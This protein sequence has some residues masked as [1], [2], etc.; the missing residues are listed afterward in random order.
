MDKS[1]TN[2]TEEHLNDVSSV[3][4]EKS[5]DLPTDEG[6][7][8]TPINNIEVYKATLTAIDEIDQ[9]YSSKNAELLEVINQRNALLDEIKALYK[10]LADIREDVLKSNELYE[11]FKRD[12]AQSVAE[13][14]WGEKIFYALPIYDEYDASDPWVVQ[15][16]DV[17]RN[18]INEENRENIRNFIN[19]NFYNS[20]FSLPKDIYYYKINPKELKDVNPDVSKLAYIFST[21]TWIFFKFIKDFSDNLR[22]TLLK[23]QLFA[24][25]TEDDFEK[26]EIPSQEEI[27]EDKNMVLTNGDSEMRMYEKYRNKGKLTEIIKN[28]SDYI[29][30]AREL[31]Q[32][33]SSFR[34]EL[35]SFEKQ[36]YTTSLMDIYRLYDSVKNCIA[37]FEKAQSLLSDSDEISNICCAKF[38]FRVKKMIGKIED[39]LSQAYRIRP[40]DIKVGEKFSNYDVMWYEVLTAEDAPNEDLIECISFI[41]DTGFAKYDINGVIEKATRV[42][43]ISVYKNTVVKEDKN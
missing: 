17:I 8:D 40:I 21:K 33:V 20:T 26:V 34:S 25:L 41:S 43:K 12:F 29:T 3:V 15:W 9:I 16:C 10:K 18:A 1:N 38:I 13:D 24:S 23:T 37:D 5:E 42:A 19:R 6:K 28:S 36:V 14:N 30:S 35:S 39:Y 4:L 31:Y 2:N 27:Q 7:N 22:Q 32:Q 11:S